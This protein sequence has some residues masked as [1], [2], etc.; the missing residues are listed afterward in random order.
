MADAQ[1][2]LEGQECVIPSVEAPRAAPGTET[3]RLIKKPFRMN[4]RIERSGCRFAVRTTDSVPAIDLELF[5][6]VPS[7]ETISVSF[8][9]LSGV[10]LEQAKTLVNAMNERIV[11]VAVFPK[12]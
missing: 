10:S 3:V 12:P 4:L 7:I 1:L 2:R 11:G 5:H 6:D 8:E 9:L